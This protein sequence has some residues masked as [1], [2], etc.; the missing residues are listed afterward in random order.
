MAKYDQFKK[1][2]NINKTGEFLVTGTTK[3]VDPLEQ[4]STQLANLYN[5]QDTS[6]STAEAYRTF[7]SQNPEI[8]EPTREYNQ[9]LAQKKEFERARESLVEDLKKKYAGEPLSTILAIAARDSKPINDQINS[10]NDSLTTLGADIKFKTDLATQEFGFYTQD[11][12]AKQAKQAKLQDLL[13]GL[14]VSQFG[15]Q[16]DQAFTREQQ[17]QNQEFDIKKMGISNI[18]DL[19]KISKSQNFQKELVSLNQKYEDSRRDRDYRNS[20]SKLEKEFDLGRQGKALDLQDNKS[21]LDYKASLDPELAEKWEEVRAKATENSS[22]ADLYGRNVGTYQGN[23]GYDL[24]GKM[25][26]AIVAPP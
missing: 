21:I 11:Q 12:Q 17:A 26:D 25:G 23:R 10:L 2:D 15:R 14:A 13:G 20:I 8:T 6:G 9:K 5:Q 16:Q 24:A 3:Q 19:E 7:I 4:L 22:L 1:I 18:Y